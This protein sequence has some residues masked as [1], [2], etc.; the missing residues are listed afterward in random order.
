MV[1]LSI[2]SCKKKEDK[3]KEERKEGRKR[4]KEEEEGKKKGITILDRGHE[5]SLHPVF[6][7]SR[8]A[9][10]PAR[11][12]LRLCGHLVPTVPRELKHACFALIEEGCFQNYEV[13]PSGKA[14]EVCEQGGNGAGSRPQ[15]PCKSP[16]R[17]ETR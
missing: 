8:T 13:V 14:G 6:M 2:H 15:L 11:A 17:Q 9:Q 7:I 5:N 1:V 16:S 4:E 10:C 3:K 12:T